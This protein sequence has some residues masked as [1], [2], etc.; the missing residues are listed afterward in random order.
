MRTSSDLEPIGVVPLLSG[1]GDSGE[2]ISLAFCGAVD[3]N[4]ISL[5]CSCL[6]SSLESGIKYFLT[7]VSA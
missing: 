3:S 6:I 7:S 1:G 5:I 2:P 4:S